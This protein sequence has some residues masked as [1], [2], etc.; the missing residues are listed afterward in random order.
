MTDMN[1]Q[2]AINCIT[3]KLAEMADGAESPPR[4]DFDVQWIHVGT[5]DNPNAWI[6]NVSIKASSEK[7]VNLADI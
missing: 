3:K 7:V 2:E 1:V 4:V 6:P 5:L